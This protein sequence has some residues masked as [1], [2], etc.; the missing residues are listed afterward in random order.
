MLFYDPVQRVVLRAV[1]PADGLD[2][3]SG[4]KCELDVLGFKAITEIAEASPGHR[5]HYLPSLI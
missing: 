4:V 2:L 5:P 1:F 3:V